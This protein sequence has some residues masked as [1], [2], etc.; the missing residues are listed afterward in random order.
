MEDEKMGSLSGNFVD[1]ILGRFG[2]VRL[3]RVRE[4][5]HYARSVG[6]RLDEHRK[7]VEAIDHKTNLFE[8]GWWHKGHMATQDDY[9]MR[10]YFFVHGEW[11]DDSGRALNN[12]RTGEYVRPRPSV[13]GESDLP[14]FLRTAK[15]VDRA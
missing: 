8:Q 3:S 11:P 12:G 4:V 5:L 10:L 6:K 2:L 13:L 9:L 15:H 7:V 14:E 1:A